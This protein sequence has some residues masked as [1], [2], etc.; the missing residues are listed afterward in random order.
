MFLRFHRRRRSRQYRALFTL[1]Y[2]KV[3]MYLSSQESRSCIFAPQK[4]RLL[5]TKPQRAGGKGSAD[6]ELRLSTLSVKGQQ[7]RKRVSAYQLKISMLLRG[8]FREI[9]TGSICNQHHAHAAL[10]I[11]QSNRNGQ[12]NVF[13]RTSSTS[14]IL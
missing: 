4:S 13:Q 14:A 11:V 1:L 10:N 3:P 5:A 9:K 7:G 8:N 2:K 6:W 12:I